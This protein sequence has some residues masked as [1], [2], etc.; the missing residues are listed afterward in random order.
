MENQTTIT[1]I[2]I[3]FVVFTIFGFVL[4]IDVG[5]TS[6]R[7]EAIKMGVGKYEI[8]DDYNP[9]GTF[10]WVIPTNNINR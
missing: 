1:I 9:V 10:T 8:T 3:I 7:K 2:S 4:G 6:V 5:Q